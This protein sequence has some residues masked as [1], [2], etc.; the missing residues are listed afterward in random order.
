MGYYGYIHN[1]DELTVDGKQYIELF[2]EYLKQK[3]EDIKIE[4]VS[5]SLLNI[6]KLNLTLFDSLGKISFLE[7][8]GEISSLIKDVAQ[9]IKRAK[10]K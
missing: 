8:I 10:H 1:G 2:K 5:F 7:N 4:H 6:E 3:S 9:A